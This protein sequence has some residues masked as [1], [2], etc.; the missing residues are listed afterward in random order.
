MAKKSF[1]IGTTGP[2]YFDDAEPQQDVS[3]TL[4]VGTNQAAIITEGQMRVLTAPVLDDEVLR[5]DDVGVNTGD[6]VGPVSAT[7][8]AVVRF[9]GTT[10]K[11]T[12]NSVVT[13]DDSGNI[14]TSGTTLTLATK[15]PASAAA[16]GDKGMIAWD[17]GYLYVC[18]DTDTWKRA[19]LVTW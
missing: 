8:E 9:D 19:E 11:R 15:T 7:N 4:P 2:F 6:V 17:S 5:L 1:W 12:Q 14:V 16:S 18:V 13:I 3:G 10:G